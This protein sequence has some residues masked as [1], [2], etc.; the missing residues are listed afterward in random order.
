MG[1]SSGS[2]IAGELWQGIEDLGLDEAKEKALARHFVRVFEAEDC[3][4]MLECSG[5][6][7]EEALALYV[8]EYLEAPEYPHEGTV[9]GDEWEGFYT[10][11]DG[12]WTRD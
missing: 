5:R 12:R 10:F 7:G 2:W 9:V 3:D 8:E 6:L 4:T 1:W 11:Q